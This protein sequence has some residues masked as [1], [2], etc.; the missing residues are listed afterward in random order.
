M[1]HGDNRG[2]KLPPKVA[3]I[4]VVVVPVMMKKEGVVEKTTEVYEKLKQEFRAEIDLRE[5]YTPGYKFNDWEL[6]GVPIRI[7]L[8]PRDIENNVCVIVRRDTLE[9]QTIDLDEINKKIKETLEDIQKNMYE[10]SKKIREERTRI[11]K[12]NVVWKRR[13]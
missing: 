7:E 3:P 1:A 2:L 5:N 12:N 9:K 13:M 10:Q 4:Q 11:Y 6:R 8:G